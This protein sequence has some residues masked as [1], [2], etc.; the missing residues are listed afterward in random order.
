MKTQWM[1]GGLMIVLLLSAAWGQDAPP[2]K[3][4]EGKP[5]LSRAEKLFKDGQEA[6]FKGE[7]ARAITLLE[8]A[9]ALDKAKTSYRL[10]L[11]RA[12]RYAGKPKEAQRLL[13]AILKITT[14][15]V[16]AGRLLAELHADRKQ[17]KEVVRV[18]GPLLKYRHDYTTY[19]LLAEAEYNLDHHKK[20]RKYYEEAIKQNPKSAQ[21]HYQLG[22]LYLTGNFFALAAE[23]YESA[24]KLGM[25]SPAL[26]YKL[27]SAYFNLRNYFGKISVVT[28]KAGKPGTIKGDWYLIEAVPGQKEVFRVAPSRSAIYQVSRVLEGGGKDR[29]DVY[30]LRANIYLNARRYHQAYRMFKEIEK[31]IPKADQALFYYYYAQ[32][33]FGVDKYDEYLEHLDQAI[34]L[35]EKT[36]ASMRVDAYVK[37]AEQYNQTGR[38]DKYIEYLAK[39]VAE[40]PK[41]AALHLKLGHAFE[42]ARK[43]KQAAD[44]WQM[45]LDLEPDHPK[46]MEL[47]NLIRRA[48]AQAGETGKRD[49]P[50]LG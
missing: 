27:A 29:P 10:Y 47:K 42:Q 45:V 3:P 23:R 9:T 8:Q 25:E 26:R 49:Y 5:E 38:L 16:E 50:Q 46:R 14:D 21:D 18:L 34:A 30:F 36:Y 19:H 15:H 41:N 35:D 44:Q 13:E 22:N 4:P 7:Y 12:Y 1:T 39:A 40:S 43:Y 33:A 37:V 17:W 11:A 48:R 28:V 2:A 32:A 24:L 31:T 6:L 20:A